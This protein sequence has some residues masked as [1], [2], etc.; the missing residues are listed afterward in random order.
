MQNIRHLFF[1]GKI[2]PGGAFDPG[3]SIFLGCIYKIFG[4]SFFAATLIQS[5]LSGLMTVVVYFIAKE[6]FNRKIGILAAML[7]ALN[8]PLI[9]LSVVLTTEA[10]YIPLLVFSIYC[11]F[12]FANSAATRA[13][14][15]YLFA[16]GII[17][18][19]AIITRAVILL[20]PLL[21]IFWLAFN[22]NNFG[23]LRMIKTFLL[24]MS[25]ILVS[26]TAITYTNTGRLEVF[27]NKH[28]MTWEDFTVKDDPRRSYSNAKLIEM[29]VNP[30]KD[31]T[32]SILNILKIPYNF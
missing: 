8:Q 31:F 23:R 22:K 9:M 15:Y 11:L 24:G 30:Y 10:L 17:M 6:V 25:I 26:I 29:G 19:M 4:Y 1:G 12:K 21:V 3:Y 18:G 5:V 28:N 13:K 32:G 7:T 16:G 2:I 27:T 14:K 20:F